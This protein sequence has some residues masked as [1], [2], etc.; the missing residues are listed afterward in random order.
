MKIQSFST[1]LL[2]LHGARA[3]AASSGQKEIEWSDCAELNSTEPIQCANLTMPLDY[4]SP[5]SSKTLDL[6]LLRIPATRQPSKGSILFNFGGPGVAGRPTMAGLGG[7]LRNATSEYHDLVTFDPRG[8]GNTIPFSCFED[9]DELN[10][11]IL[12]NP[13]AWALMTSPNFSSNSSDVTPGRLWAST[14]LLVDKCYEKNQEIGGLY[15]TAFVARDMM[16]IVDALGEDGLLRYWGYSY[17]TILG[18]TA[19]AMFPDRIDRMVLDGNLNGHEYYNAWDDEQWASADE[20][21]SA[22]FQS[23]VASPSTCP[24]A[25][26]NQT[27][28]ELEDATYALMN[29]LNSRPIPFNGTWIDYNVVKAGIM[30]ALYNPAYWPLLTRGLDALMSGNYTLFTEMSAKLS[31]SYDNIGTSSDAQL[32][33]RCGDKIARVDTLD[34]FLPIMDRQVRSSKIFGDIQIILEMICA[35]WRLN[36]KER[37]AG[38]FAVKTRHPLMFIGNTADAF[39]PLVSA[40][41]MSDAFEGSRVL[42]VD[43]YGHGSFGVSRCAA[44]ATAD[45]YV[46]G[47]LPKED[48]FCE[49]DV[50]I[51]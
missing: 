7:A 40:K 50:P 42:H 30:S 1:A 14:K 19:A 28:Q 2:L 6:Q 20:A 23:C 46:N 33:I 49:L 26:R 47:T 21:F 16:Q 29:N 5:N 39:A 4:T 35:Q 41:N 36:A 48:A 3:D 31:S 10:A 15:G 25:H 17:G 44:L 22:V 18:Q 11:Y 9:Q 24:L 43:G 32:Q 8:T 45:Y 37:Y 51:L 27:A 38:D 34:E 12:R 13:K